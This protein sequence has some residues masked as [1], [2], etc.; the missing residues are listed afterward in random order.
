MVVASHLNDYLLVVISEDL[1]VA[2]CEVFV[3]KLFARVSHARVDMARQ[4]KF[5]TSINLSR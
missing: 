2:I 1:E 5:A 4:D 3:P